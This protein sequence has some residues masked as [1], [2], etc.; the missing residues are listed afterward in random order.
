MNVSWCCA[1]C[2]AVCE[3]REVTSVRKDMTS[4]VSDACDDVSYDEAREED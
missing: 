1:R 4:N 2:G 3:M